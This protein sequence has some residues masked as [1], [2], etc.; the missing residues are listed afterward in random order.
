MLRDLRSLLIRFWRKATDQRWRKSVFEQGCSVDA[1]TFLEGHNR[2]CR[3]ANARGA[4]LG[5]ATYIGPRS[6]LSSCHIGRWCSIGSDVRVVVGR[7]PTRDFVSTHPAFFSTQGQ[8]GFTFVQ[9][10]SFPEFTY[11][12]P[13]TRQYVRIGH[14]VWIG[15]A[16]ILIAGI[17]IGSGAVV[18]AGAVVT[19]DVVP[20]AIVGGV[21]ARTIGS[22]FD[23]ETMAWLLEAEWWNRDFDWLRDHARL[24]SDATLLRNEL[25]AGGTGSPESISINQRDHKPS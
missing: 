7:H 6:N 17:E 20:Y 8:A 12:C 2:V 4:H 10:T 5:L 14:D 1:R 15:E 16:A 11:A 9:E 3:G 19:K 23:P 21:P 24:F 13:E 18:A 25:E 22:R